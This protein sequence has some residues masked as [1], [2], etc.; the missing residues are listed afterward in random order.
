MKYDA[1]F[2]G[3]C[4]TPVVDDR[5]SP[6]LC[7]DMSRGPR[8]TAYEIT[9]TPMGITIRGDAPSVARDGMVNHLAAA[10][11]PC[12][13]AWFVSELDPVHLASK[14]LRPTWTQESS[15]SH[16][17]LLVEQTDDLLANAR[18]HAIWAPQARKLR[19]ILKAHPNGFESEVEWHKEVMP[20]LSD[21]ASDDDPVLDED[22]LIPPDG[23]VSQDVELL[24]GLQRR[25]RTL[26]L[27]TYPE[28][29]GSLATQGR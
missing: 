7:W 29:A 17:I 13:L 12:N 8:I 9:F 20:L 1:W 18:R 25:F 4:L 10:N 11:Q 5:Q 3:H 23:Y 26:F 16:L 2:K 27:E 22:D 28:W 19:A 14:F 15:L 21:L 6:V 24:S